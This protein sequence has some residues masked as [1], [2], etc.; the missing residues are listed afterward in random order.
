MSSILALSSFHLAYVTGDPENK[1]MAYHHKVTA[2]R[3]LQTA[4]TSFS[5]GNCE[6]ILAASVL[7]SWQANER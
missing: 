5:K 6:A 3:G 7:L 1:Q 4:I 2:F